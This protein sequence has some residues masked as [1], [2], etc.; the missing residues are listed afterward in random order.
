[1]MHARSSTQQ[2]R[3]LY[4]ELLE[5]ARQAEAEGGARIDFERIESIA[6]KNEF[7]H[8]MQLKDRHAQE[9]QEAVEMLD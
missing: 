3:P 9:M 1:M 5:Q 4:Q 8:K 2:Q 7:F 6:S